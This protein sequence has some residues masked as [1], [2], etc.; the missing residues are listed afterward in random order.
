MIPTRLFF[1]MFGMYINLFSKMNCLM[2]PILVFLNH[3]FYL[4][5]ISIS[6]ELFPVI[7]NNISPVFVFLYIS[8]NKRTIF[9]KNV[10]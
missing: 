1:K 3:T 7:Q 2:K 9:S 8:L 4:L 5:S 6:C 10:I